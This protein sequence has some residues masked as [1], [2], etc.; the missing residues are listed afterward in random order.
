MPRKLFTL[1][2]LVSFALTAFAPVRVAAGPLDLLV[3][4]SFPQC[5]DAKVLKKIVKR[6]NWAED[7][8]WKRGFYL[9]S[10]ERIRER[11]VQN[12]GDR[13]IPRR[14]CRAHALL[15]NGNHPTVFYLIEGGQGFAGNSFNVEFCLNGL[16][17]W[18]EY[19]GSCRV[20]RW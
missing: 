7:Y 1:L 2:A 9:E 8:N 19:D 16:D 20:L 11:V 4:G 3:R 12:A 6:F 15:T 13:Q 18:N 17:P 14:Y 10:I 5:D